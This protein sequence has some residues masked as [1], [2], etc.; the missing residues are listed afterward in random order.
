MGSRKLVRWCAD[1][2]E[3]RC[4]SPDGDAAA[5]AEVVEEGGRYWAVR[6]R[7]WNHRLEIVAWMALMRPLPTCTREKNVTKRLTLTGPEKLSYG[8]VRLLQKL[9]HRTDVVTEMA[10]GAEAG[11]ETQVI[12]RGDAGIAGAL[13]QAAGSRRRW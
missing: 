12:L 8:V 6:N 10:V 7:T 5:V 1:C 11:A 13:D 4:L 2:A 9:W 3:W